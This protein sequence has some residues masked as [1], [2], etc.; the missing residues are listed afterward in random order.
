MPR[1]Y[2]GFQ[3]Y[4][5]GRESLI[6]Q[7]A[8][9]V[10]QHDLREFVPVMRVEKGR[11]GNLF[12]L[13][14]AI[15][16]TEAGEIPDEIC[17]PLLH[18]SALHKPVP[19]PDGSGFHPFTLE[20]IRPMVGV[21]HKVYNYARQI[22]YVPRKS[23]EL[24]DPFAYQDQAVPDKDVH[25]EEMLLRSHRY[26]RL[27]HWLSA[28]GS[29]SWQIFQNVCHTLGLEGKQD[30]PAQVLRRLRLLGHI[31][32]SPDRARWSSTPTVLVP[33]ADECSFFLC[34]QRDNVTLQR[35]R[36]VAHVEEKVQPKGEAPALVL[37]NIPD[38]NAFLK[39]ILQMEPLIRVAKN[40][41]LRLAQI[42][43]ALTDWK[44]TLETLPH[45]SPYQYQAK[46]F[47][48]T[49]FVEA[50]FDRSASGFYQFWPLKQTRSASD[51]PEYTLFYDAEH[52]QFLRGDWYGLRFLALQ[53][54]GVP[55]PVA[56]EVSSRRLAVPWAWRWPELYERALVLASGQLPSYHNK[57]L[58][59]EAI[60]PQILAELTSKLNL[61]C[62]EVTESCMMS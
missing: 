33:S 6:R 8:Q 57:C 52:E 50:D 23:Y 43:P 25:V 45:F 31:E 60:T 37:I 53:A 32:T 39:R 28:A 18:L 20:E 5:K 10:K 46:R 1:W 17:M 61:E 7:I 54:N 13:F 38:S 55:C 51:R 41:A 48:S 9:Q 26:D 34:G 24:R 27:L 30:T 12:Y 59:Y 11:R 2:A 19:G 36:Q 56:Y 62:E 14:L 21:E 3:C 44:H 40:A 16:G 29:G 42:L 15:E 49:D 22:P 4:A 58:I 35:L 47:F